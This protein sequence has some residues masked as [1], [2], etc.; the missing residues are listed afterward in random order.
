MPRLIEKLLKTD[1]SGSM[2]KL[3]SAQ[4]SLSTAQKATQ[5]AQESFNSAIAS[6]AGTSY[7]FASNA[8]NMQSF[9]KGMG[10]DESNEYAK[11]AQSYQSS[12]DSIAKSLGI[13][14]S[15]A[16]QLMGS[17]GFGWDN[18]WLPGLKANV[19]G[20]TQY[21]QAQK[22]AF[23]KATTGENGKK[24]DEASRWAEKV[25]QNSGW[26]DVAQHGNTASKKIASGVLETRQRASA[27]T[28]AKANETAAQQTYAQAVQTAVTANTNMND[29]AGFVGERARKQWL[30]THHGDHAGAELAS[31]QA[32]RDFLMA[33]GANPRDFMSAAPTI[34]NATLIA[35]QNPGSYIDGVH[36]KNVTGVNGAGDPTALAG[37]AKALYEGEMGT[38]QAKVTAGMNKLD[39]DINGMKQ[40]VDAFRAST[41]KDIDGNQTEALKAAEAS[42]LISFDDKTG[43]YTVNNPSSLSG[44]S[45]R[46]IKK[47]NTA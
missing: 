9:T 25:N 24:L 11:G 43:K 17:A 32:A 6:N 38:A 42:G 40:R 5:T 45:T 12:A 31:Q 14:S 41:G 2:Q 21:S 35:M 39:K 19:N 26:S 44:I 4:Q 27:L 10:K 37:N 13:D 8:S 30:R 28:A 34:P 16:K 3:Q 7:D 15:Q 47:N 20:S 29:T 1:I 33:Q 46:K 36:A 18:S 22:D 23:N